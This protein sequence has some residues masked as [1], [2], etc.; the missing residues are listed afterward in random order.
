MAF[1]PQRGQ[2]GEIRNKDEDE[3]KNKE[4]GNIRT[5]NL[6]VARAPLCI[7]TASKRGNRRISSKLYFTDHIGAAL[8]S[9]K[10]VVLKWP[11]AARLTEK[12]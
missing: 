3:D 5:T 1:R 11:Q 2:A 12:S 7:K 4:R 9:A 10:I 6:G 8:E